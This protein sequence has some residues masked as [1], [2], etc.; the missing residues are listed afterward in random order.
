MKKVLFSI[1]CLFTI[2]I[3]L[4]AKND[5]YIYDEWSD[6]ER[7]PD[8]YTVSSV[9]YAGDLNLNEQ[10]KTPSSVFCKD[11]YV[12]LVDSG[13]NR[14]LEL[15]YNQNKTVTLNRVID[16]FVCDDPDV[17]TTF[18]N[19]SDIFVNK[20]HTIFIA[21]TN[22]GRVVKLDYDLNYLMTFVQPDSELY[23]KDKSFFPLKVVAD[24]VG[25]LYIAAKNV[26]K[27]FVK[28]ESDGT[29]TGF[30]GASEVIY[31][32]AQYIWKKYFSTRAQRE[33][34]ENFV[35]TEY[36]N[37]YI[38]PEGFVYAVTETFE[39]WDLLSDKAK[40]IRKLNS[41]GKDILIKNGDTP[42]IGDLQWSLG[43]G[44]KD[45]SHF[46]DITVL[47]DEVYLAL[48]ESRSR[49]FAYDNQG[50]LLFAFGNKG[51]IDGYFRS[52]VA[53]DHVGKDLFVVDAVNASLTILT[54]TEY[55]NYI[56]LATEYFNNG[57]Y[58]KSAEQW[59]NVLSLNGNYDLAYLGLGKSEYRKE[60]YKKAMDYFK[61]K[62]YRR[63]YSKA[64]QYYR[65]EWIEANLYKIVIV[66]VILLI[67]PLIVKIIK[68]F[69]RELESL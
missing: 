15:I 34:M 6:L 23:D 33:Q 14:I 35:P 1:I 30:F 60:N 46:S 32:T 16:S 13:N 66:I 67:I 55:G 29:F 57:E 27:G 54:P 49:I 2:C 5:T 42:P 19:P 51:N 18:N 50:E 44:V 47:E 24:E 39:E 26:N 9:L 59:G 25:R 28:Y 56:Y 40:P 11:N 68:R 31:N 17:I 53:I 41:L 37:A 3:G 4:Y 36:S 38:D 7:S 21:D 69:K 58:D 61:V 12:Y 22:N 65:K 43:A 52:P 20:D 62:K 64:F 8:V 10:L 48:D 63:W 45:P